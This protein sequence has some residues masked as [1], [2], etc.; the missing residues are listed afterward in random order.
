MCCEVALGAFV[1]K[2]QIYKV[3]VNFLPWRERHT[4]VPRSA[5]RLW[6]PLHREQW[7][8]TSHWSSLNKQESI[9]DQ[10][11]YNPWKEER[12]WFPCVGWFYGWLGLFWII[13]MK[14]FFF[15]MCV[16]GGGHYDPSACSATYISTRFPFQGSGY[17][18]TPNAAC[19]DRTHNSN[20][21]LFKNTKLA[22]MISYTP[23]L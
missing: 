2:K 13:S 10:N 3:W 5:V 6:S 12:C 23:S 22:T 20:Y 8:K 17:I 7:S 15:S 18:Y 9:L 16:Y 11:A 19:F 4:P 14:T 1:L 21:S